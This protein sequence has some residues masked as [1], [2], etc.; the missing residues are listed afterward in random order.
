M[1]KILFGMLSLVFVAL[2][3]AFALHISA[4]ADEGN[5]EEVQL[6]NGY[7]VR[8]I[9]AETPTVGENLIY[10]RILDAEKTPI[11]NAR[12][13]ASFT[14]VKVNHAKAHTSSEHDMPGM[15]M[16]TIHA[17]TAY[18]DPY[19]IQFESGDQRGEYA[20]EIDLESRG[21]YVVAIHMIVD[22][23]SMEAEFPLAVKG[24][25]MRY[26]ILAVF[27]GMNLIIL[28]VAMTLRSKHVRQ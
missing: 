6:I 1:K 21:D 8:L 5:H 18:G 10:V 19:V 26:A 16:N 22:N 13:E 17:S 24:N 23:D 28:V 27:L 9:F 2:F 15:D 20:G 11:A 14:P 7:E 3:T 25:Y 12:I 4:R